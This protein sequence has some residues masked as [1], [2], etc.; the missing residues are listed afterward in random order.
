MLG[1]V[2]ILT[3]RSIVKSSLSCIRQSYQLEEN[4]SQSDIE[5]LFTA[6]SALLEDVLIFQFPSA[7]PGHGFLCPLPDCHW[8]LNMIN[9]Q[10][11][12]SVTAV[13][14]AGDSLQVSSQT[15]SRKES[16]YGNDDFPI[17]FVHFKLAQHCLMQAL[18]ST[19]KN[20]NRINFNVQVRGIETTHI[21]VLF[22][23]SI[24]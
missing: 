7:S 6:G 9:R 4:E 11:H 10:H 15:L 12:W 23:T 21:D 19:A 8:L 20:S 16:V 17:G 18:Q 1:E 2:E 22:I 5:A 24:L 3:L 14:Q 13:S